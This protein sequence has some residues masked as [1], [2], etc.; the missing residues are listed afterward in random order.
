MIALAEAPRATD[1]VIKIDASARPQTKQI[2]RANVL[3]I[4]SAIASFRK[5]LTE[6]RDLWLSLARASFRDGGFKLRDAVYDPDHIAR[7]TQILAGSELAGRTHARQEARK[8]GSDVT[9]QFDEPTKPKTIWEILKSAVRAADPPPTRE[10]EWLK[11]LPRI[12]RAKWDATLARYRQPAFFITGVE[13]RET[14]R[15]IQDQIGESLRLG[16]TLK[17]FEDAVRDSL[18]NLALTGGRLRNVWHNNVGN[19]LRKGRY[20]ELAQPEI[21]NLLGYFLFDALVDGVVRPNHAALEGG[22]AP[23]SWPGWS[24]YGD[25]LGHNCRC[26]RTSLTEARA[27]SMIESGEGFDLT[28]GVPAGAGPDPG[29]VKMI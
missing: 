16:H 19:A 28:A 1:R 15:I 25:P 8:A 27:I 13:Q 3:F 11:G 20:D 18:D 22:I 23:Q 6:N 21:R 12:T 24:K 2:L 4:R 10:I 7:L 5:S 17:Q 29:F 14:L 26:C 9:L